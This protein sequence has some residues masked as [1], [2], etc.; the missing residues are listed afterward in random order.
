MVQFFLIL[1]MPMHSS[2]GSVDGL[3]SQWYEDVNSIQPK[4]YHRNYDT[5][6]QALYRQNRAPACKINH[7][8]ISH[9]CFPFFFC[10]KRTFLLF[11]NS[12]PYV[13]I[14]FCRYRLNLYGNHYCLQI[15]NAC[16][17]FEKTTSFH[18]RILVLYGITLLQPGTLRDSKSSLVS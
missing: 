11:I 12:H 14:I 1:H 13:K 2:H 17:C 5:A 15:S 6:F 4:F 7:L 9:Y 3:G 8:S 16:I 18:R 10:I